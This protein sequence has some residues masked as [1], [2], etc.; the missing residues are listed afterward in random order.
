M[1][2]KALVVPVMLALG[3]YLSTKLSIGPSPEEA[4]FVGFGLVSGYFW[5]LFTMW[6]QS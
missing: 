5:G 1:I 3:A 4:F 2:T 6:F